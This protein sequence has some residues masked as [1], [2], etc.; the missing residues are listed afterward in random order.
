MILQA[1]EYEIL[2]SATTATTTTTTTTPTPTSSNTNTTNTNNTANS[3]NLQ[4]F[5][6]STDGYFTHPEV[7][8]W[9][10]ELVETRNKRL[11]R[12]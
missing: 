9:A 12:S 1:N 8:S 10:R 7:A 2:H 5:F 3:I 6:D 4:E 11:G